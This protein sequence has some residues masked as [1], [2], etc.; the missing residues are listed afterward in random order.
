MDTPRLDPI[1]AQ[2]VAKLRPGDLSPPLKI[3][4]EFH[5]MLLLE[6]LP[7]READPQEAYLQIEEILLAQKMGVAYN[8]WIA[9]HLKKATIKVSS[10]FLQYLRDEGAVPDSAGAGSAAKPAS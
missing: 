8:E 1:L 3:N 9:G 10:R 7:A 6:S 2:E 4:D 5:Q